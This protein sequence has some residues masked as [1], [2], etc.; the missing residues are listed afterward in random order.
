AVLGK[1]SFLTGLGL[2]G[3]GNFKDVSWMAPLGTGMMASALTLPEE[4]AN[5][6][7][8]SFSEEAKT[9][10]QRLVNMKESFLSKTYLDKLFHTTTASNGSGSSKTNQ[11]TI[12][13]PEENTTENVNGFEEALATSNETLDEIEK[14]LIASAR[15]YQQRQQTPAKP[16]EGTEPEMMGLGE[17]V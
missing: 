8:F 9:V 13:Q 2:V 4:P 6:A 12:A 16:V 7:P 17:E 15:A 14:Q 10:K 11:R 3:I 5:T 1:W